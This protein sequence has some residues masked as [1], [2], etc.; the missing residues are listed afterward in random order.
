[1]ATNRNSN[2]IEFT[3]LVF[4][5]YYYRDADYF[6]CLK[7]MRIDLERHGI[8]VRCNGLNQ[9]CLF[10][11]VQGKFGRLPKGRRV[12][13]RSPARPA[14]LVPISTT[15]MRVRSEPSPNKPSSAIFGSLAFIRDEEL[16]CH[17]GERSRTADRG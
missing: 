4:G 5:D 17:Y 16:G 7:R 15:P 10:C 8:R 1:M 14:D 6:A 11:Y 3:H 13:L 2:S 9:C 12:K